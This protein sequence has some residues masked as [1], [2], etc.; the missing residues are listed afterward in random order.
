MLVLDMRLTVCET[1]WKVR[2]IYQMKYVNVCRL[3]HM[4]FVC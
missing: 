3:V 4:P 1:R 2:Y